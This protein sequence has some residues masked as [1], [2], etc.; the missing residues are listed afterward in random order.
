MRLLFSEVSNFLNS[1]PLVYESGDPN[2]PSAITPNHFLLLRPNS[3][4]PAREYAVMSPRRHF[5]YMER[6]IDDVWDRSLESGLD[7]VLLQR[8]RITLD[9][10]QVE[11]RYPLSGRL[12]SWERLRIGRDRCPIGIPLV[13]VLKIH[14]RYA[15]NSILPP[16]SHMYEFKQTK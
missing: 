16:S 11:I 1:R 14:A 13:L 4:V 8:V 6:L 15:L 3:T 12:H 10:G 5:H 2:E 7:G 9:K